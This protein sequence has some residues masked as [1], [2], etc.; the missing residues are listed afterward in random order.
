[1]I[2]I[3]GGYYVMYRISAI[4]TWAKHA[5]IDREATF[6]ELRDR[7]ESRINNEFK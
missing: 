1:M 7:L 5:I 6:E 2:I 4:S 3:D